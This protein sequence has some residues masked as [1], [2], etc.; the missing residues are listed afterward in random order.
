MKQA[1]DWYK[2]K[3]QPVPQNAGHVRANRDIALFSTIF[4]YAH[5]V[6]LTSAPNPAQG[7]RKNK[8]SDRD[9]YV[10]NGLYKAVYDKADQPLMDAMDV[11]YLTGQRPADTLKL[12]ED[13]IINGQLELQQGKTKKKLRIQIIGKLAQVIERILA[14]KATYKVASRKLIVN[15]QGQALGREALRS[16]FDKAREAANIRKS[17]FQFRGLRAKAG[18]DKAESS[19]DIRQAQKQ[20]GHASVA[21]TETYVRKRKGDVTTPT[22]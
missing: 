20:L 3:G 15:G 9:V 5:E 18:T 4:N 14:R 1:A 17:A 12:S 16:R 2:D 7:V 8:E 11:A 10:E 19:K 22:E 6:G 13:H 21:M